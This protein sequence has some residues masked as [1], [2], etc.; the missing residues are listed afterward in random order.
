MSKTAP[1]RWSDQHLNQL[2]VQME[3]FKEI[4]KTKGVKSNQTNNSMSV[5]QLAA[6]RQLMHQ[7]SM[8]SYKEKFEHYDLDYCRLVSK[9]YRFLF[10]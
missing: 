2:R 3:A 6:Q 4:V 1:V 7:R 8:D 5:L 10:V 9:S